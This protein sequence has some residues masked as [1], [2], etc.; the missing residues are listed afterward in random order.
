MT[1]LTK[2]QFAYVQARAEGM[3][4]TQS[5]LAAG[6]SRAGANRQGSVL[7]KM[8]KI[9]AAIAK[10]KKA[11]KKGDAIT[12]D[13]IES[14][15]GVPAG[16]GSGEEPPRMKPKYASS[17]ELLKD[18]YNNP[19]MPDSIRLRAAE[20]ALPY[21]HGRIGEKGKKEQKADAAKEA[22]SGGKKE[23]GRLTPKAPPQ[24]PMLRAVGGTG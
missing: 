21:E 11:I 19:R 8:P 9:K 10:A 14:F 13:Q 20:Q 22:M 15:M 7:E 4:I 23:R 16:K 17:L 5:A 24:R 18:T 1:T 2:L 6:Y 3:N 12:R